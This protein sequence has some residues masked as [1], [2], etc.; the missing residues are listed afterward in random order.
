MISKGL[1]WLGVFI[2][3]T[4]GGCIP[5]VWGAGIFSLSSVLLSAVGG[6]FGIWVAVKVSNY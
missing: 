4:I 2:G 1:V 5:M 3:S 6:L